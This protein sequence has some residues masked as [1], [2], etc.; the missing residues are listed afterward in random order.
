LT[1]PPI[2]DLHTRICADLMPHLA[3]WRRHDMQ[4]DQHTPPSFITV[5]GAMRDYARDV[6]AR[7]AGAAEAPDHLPESTVAL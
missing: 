2:Q 7:L 4:V 5:P 6:S 1:K 3:G